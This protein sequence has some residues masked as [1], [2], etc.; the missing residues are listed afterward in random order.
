MA[1][2]CLGYLGQFDPLT[3]ALG[4]EDFRIVWPDYFDEL[5]EAIARGPETAFAIHQSL[6]K[7]YGDDAAELYRMLWGYTDIDLGSGEDA[8]LVKDLDHEALV[9]RVLAFSNL[10]EIMNQTTFG[11]RPEAP[12]QKRAQPVQR[13][14]QEQQAGR[15]RHTA[16]KPSPRKPVPPPEVEPKAAPEAG[17]ATTF[18]RPTGA[19]ER[20]DAPRGRAGTRP[21][22]ATAS[23]VRQIPVAI[24]E[25]DPPAARPKLVYP[26]PL[27]SDLP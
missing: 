4:K 26:E 17:E 20:I 27:S 12:A 23:A 6:E 7:Q 2:R 11:Y 10:K 9:Y 5:K 21:G 8:R 14:K 1:A 24:P 25:P 16:A 13:W 19:S 18:V 3:E 22:T 15:I